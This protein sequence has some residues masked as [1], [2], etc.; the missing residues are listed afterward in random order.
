DYLDFYARRARRIL[1]AMAVVIMVTLA[2]SISFLSR[3][4]AAEAGKAGMAAFL[5]AANLYFAKASTGYFDVGDHN[6]LL[7]LW[8]LGVE[9][10]FYLL[11]PLVLMLARKRPLAWLAAIT[12]VSFAACE[13]LMA[14]GND[15]VAFYMMPTR[16]WELAVGG[17]IAVTPMRLPR[18]VGWIGIAATAAAIAHLPG[19]FP[20]VGVVPAVLGAGLVVAAAHAGQRNHLLEAPLLRYVGRI[21]YSLY[22]WHWPVMLFGGSEPAWLQL[23][24]A[25][26][27]AV[28]SYHFVE[29]PIRRRYAWPASRIVAAGALLTVAGAATA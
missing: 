4:D 23:S 27:L 13:W 19:R 25:F 3:E 9:E 20:G 22:L 6:P 17:L 16:A 11:W 29:T 21:S 15:Q 18:W 1:P 14:R 28:L 26:G 2:A 12:I 10:Q 5:F 8:S 7:H 24:T